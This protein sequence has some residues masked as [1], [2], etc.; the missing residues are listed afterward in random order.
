MGVCCLLLL[1]LLL[2]VWLWVCCS[3][4]FFF[5]QLRP[6]LFSSVPLPL[7][8]CCG[9]YLLCAC[10]TATSPRRRRSKHARRVRWFE[11]QYLLLP[12][13]IFEL[14]VLFAEPI[15]L[16]GVWGYAYGSSVSQAYRVV[17]DQRNLADKKG[18]W[19]KC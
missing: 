12:Q 6:P 15:V 9:V 3:F 5:L 2:F 4:G 7:T 18:A 1:L 19:K 17:P 11:L 8:N 16:G 10:C 13:Y 14:D